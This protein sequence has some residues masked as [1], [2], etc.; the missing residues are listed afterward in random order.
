MI[1]FS[2]CPRFKLIN[3]LWAPVNTLLEKEKKFKG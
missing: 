3:N 2:W 1:G